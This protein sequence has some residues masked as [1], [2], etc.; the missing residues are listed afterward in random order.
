MLVLQHFAVYST[1]SHCCMSYLSP[2]C[3]AQGQSSHAMWVSWALMEAQQGDATAARYLF[4]RCM[5][6]GPRSR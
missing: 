4:K 2:V 3:L 6:V 1:F 5:D